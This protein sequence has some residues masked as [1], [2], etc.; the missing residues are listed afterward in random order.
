MIQR[1]HDAS[2]GFPASE[3]ENAFR[4]ALGHERVIAWQTAPLVDQ[5]GDVVRIIAG[6]IDITDRKRREVEL[7]RQ[8]DFATTVANTI[9]SF[10]VVTDHD[11]IVVENGANRAFVETFGRSVEE[12]E[13]AS[14]LGL[15]APDD[16]FQARMA[17]AGAA[18][19]V[20]Q[21]ERE[22]RWLTCDG[23]ELTVAWTATPI[24]DQ[25]GAPRVL[26]S[27]ADVTE[28]KRQEAEVKASRSRI[29]A[30]TDAARRRLERNLHDG[31][32]QRLAA[33]SLS[34]R[35]AESKLETDVDQAAEIL[36]SART[37]LAEALDE[38]R[39]L[40]RGLHPN[41]LTDR[42]LGPA[43][44]TLVARSPIPVE[45]HVTADR[46]LPA[47]EAAAYYVAAEALANVAKYAH[48]TFA[49]V[50][51]V[52]D[53]EEGQILVEVSDDGVG[54]ADPARGSGLEG[55]EDRIEAL[56]GTFAVES[57]PGGG[58]RIRATI[59]AAPRALPL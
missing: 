7:Q 55:L 2:P 11:A 30:A 14:F 49:E 32:Q 22:S 43:L 19:G 36:V 59:P 39:E 24:V 17:I 45:V 4:N 25:W 10:I 28:R 51:V 6:G 50:R 13:G 9:P 12:L 5:N 18:N 8:W 20:P 53:V 48:A 33:L 52:E 31:A 23:N 40:A 46:F 34:L 42:G 56:D 21:L 26:V 29:V 54:G 1:F 41:V 47:I 35:L 58:T 15:V 57:P 3:Y 16:E 44:E 27:G 38:L 37:E